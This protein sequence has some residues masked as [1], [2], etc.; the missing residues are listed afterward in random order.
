VT[1]D[2]LNTAL[3]IFFA[4]FFGLISGLLITFGVHLFIRLDRLPEAVRA[5]KPGW[6]IRL[7]TRSFWVGIVIICSA[8]A[9]AVLAGIESRTAWLALS[10][11]V[12]LGFGFA[13]ELELARLQRDIEHSSYDIF[14]R[15]LAS[16]FAEVLAPTRD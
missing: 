7:S 5:E 16:E 15:T 6:I 9:V 8:G 3:V 4:L 12:G 14:P 10:F 2:L 11:S 13:L 1:I